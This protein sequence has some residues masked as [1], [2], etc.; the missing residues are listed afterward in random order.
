M[1]RSL[2][3]SPEIKAYVYQRLQEFEPYLLPNTQTGVFIQRAKHV[4]NSEKEHFE[5]SLTLNTEGGKLQAHGVADDVYAA[6]SQ[7]SQTLMNQISTIHNAVI[8]S[9]ERNQEIA[10]AF[11][12]QYLH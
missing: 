1:D 5:V 9:Q 11:R 2:E 3:Q 12:N 4:T 8:S 6:I 10:R 7:A